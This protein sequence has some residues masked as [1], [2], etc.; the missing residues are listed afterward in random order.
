ML[1]MV[2]LFFVETW[3]SW[4]KKRISSL[5]FGFRPTVGLTVRFGK[6]AGAR[7]T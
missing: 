2:V 1:S 7:Q 3:L 4:G 6:M 5:R